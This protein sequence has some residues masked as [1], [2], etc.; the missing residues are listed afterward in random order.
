MSWYVLRANF[1]HEN[2]IAETIRDWGLPFRGYCPL[3]R[4]STIVR[5][6]KVDKLLPLWPT[7]LMADWT[8][9]DGEAWHRVMGVK[10]VSGM[11][12][13]GDPFP[14]PDKTIEEWTSRTDSSG[15]VLGLEELFQRFRRGYDRG[16]RVRI[17]G[18]PF[19]GAIG[20]CEWYDD[21]GVQIKTAL[22]G[23]EVTIYA[24]L[25]SSVRIIGDGSRVIGD[26]SRTIVRSKSGARRVR[27]NL[28]KSGHIHAENFR[29]MATQP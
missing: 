19:D 20:T 5:G 10:G 6:R 21:K 4:A 29:V 22:L 27:R 12:G 23:R 14:V 17:E 18:G 16:D 1:A 9:G 2:A 13:A 24:S 25:A 11:L 26:G 28:T 15:V 3:R 7:Y 8:A